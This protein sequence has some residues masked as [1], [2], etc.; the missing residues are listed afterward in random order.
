MALSEP[1]K[2]SCADVA[3]VARIDFARGDVSGVDEFAQP[4]GGFWVVFIVVVH[5]L[6]FCCHVHTSKPTAPKPKAEIM[7]SL[8]YGSEAPSN[9]IRPFNAST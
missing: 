3:D 1:N 2:V 4:F 8:G 5:A 9:V 6:A 7:Q